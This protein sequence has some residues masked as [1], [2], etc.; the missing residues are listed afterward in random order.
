MY[1][2]ALKRHNS[3]QNKTNRKATLSFVHKQLIFKLQQE[4]FEN[5]MISE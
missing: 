5:S 2:F 1:S 4:K 3:F